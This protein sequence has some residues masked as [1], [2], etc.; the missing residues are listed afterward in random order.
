MNIR[1]LL[2]VAVVLALVL[3]MF[4]TVV[5]AQP[6][7][8]AI[9]GPRVECIRTRAVADAPTLSAGNHAS[10]LDRVASMP[11]YAL[12]YYHWMEDNIGLDGI[13]VDPTKGTEDGGEYYYSVHYATGT[14][15][16]T[17]TS[18][19]E[20]LATGG[21]IAAA[22]LDKEFNSFSNWVSV[23]HDIF[24]REHPEV[25]WLS[26]RSSISYMGS[27]SYS[28]RGDTCT[29]MYQADLVVWLNYPGFDIR[30]T[31]YQ[32]LG[33][34]K[35]AIETRDSLVQEILADCPEASDYDRVVYLNDVLTARNAYNS[36]VAA[37]NSSKAE[38]DAWECISALEGRSGTDGPVC[39]GY[40]RAFQVLCNEL[41]IPCVLVDGEAKTDPGDAPESHMWNYVQIDDG[42]YAI[43]VTWN[44]PYIAATP[45]E[46]ITGRENHDWMLLGSDS[47]VVPGYT[48]LE[49]H[50]VENQVRSGGLAFTNGPVLEKTAYQVDTDPVYTV[51]GTLISGSA[52][53]LTLELLQDGVTVATQ[54]ISGKAAIYNF[55]NIP[56]GTY[57]MKLTKLNHVP[58]EYTVTVGDGDLALDVKIHLIGDIDG[59]GRV[60]TGDVAKLNAHLKG[61]SLLTDE[62]MLLCANVNGGRLN[63]GDTATLYSH[64]KGT[65][66]LY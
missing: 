38:A 53:E 48:F 54:I 35:A 12:D 51:S 60:N 18:K 42:W 66:L 8:F 61:S 37:G 17:F 23:I 59:N 22:G 3:G 50:E 2:S 4:P 63:M 64:V 43:D 31:K 10:Y 5:F 19:D 32:D 16:F 45:E 9:E 62:Y 44:D 24:D 47:E 58:R 56:S 7:S 40:A 26:G 25:F 55:D 11:D 14:E 27:W 6:T 20:M 13:L 65:K 46:K 41:N 29:I 36:A 52:G 39:E 1:K 28:T 57:Q 33:T 49:S 15:R 21:Q 30:S 34:L